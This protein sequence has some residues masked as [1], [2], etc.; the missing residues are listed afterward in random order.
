[1][2]YDLN[3]FKNNMNTVNKEK[4]EYDIEANDQIAK[5]VAIDVNIPCAASTGKHKKDNINVNIVTSLCE[6]A[7]TKYGGRFTTLL[8]NLIPYFN[9]VE[10][11]RDNTE[12]YLRNILTNIDIELGYTKQEL[13]LMN[14]PI[15]EFSYK[16]SE[17]S[18]SDNINYRIK[19][20]LDI[21]YQEIEEDCY[22]YS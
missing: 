20:I 22:A 19:S 2:Y 3:R 12:E 15:L 1:M 4:C 6:Y 14:D 18:K 8:S 17:L 16:S 5:S 11:E 10:V 9:N 13:E 21:F 7:I